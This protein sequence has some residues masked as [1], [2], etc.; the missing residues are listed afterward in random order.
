M[1]SSESANK[2]SQ[3]ISVRIRCRLGSRNRLASAASQKA[4]SRGRQRA[5]VARRWA[6]SPTSADGIATSTLPARGAGKQPLRPQDQNDDHDGV[7][8]EG[9]E[10]GHVILARDVGDA[11]QKR[12]GE[13][14]G[15]A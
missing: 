9:S 5:R 3:A 7:D 12:S 15:D 11:D 4:Y 1:R 13:G 14:T 10:F 2:A 8:H 6:T